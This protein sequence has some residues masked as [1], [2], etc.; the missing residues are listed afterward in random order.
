MSVKYPQVNVQLVGMDGNAFSI[1]GNVVR[2]MKKAKLYDEASEF[3]KAAFASESYDAL[4]RLVM[5]TVNCDDDDDTDIDGD[6]SDENEREDRN[7]G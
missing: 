4:L 6:E 7:F 1:I 3:S 2:A 5:E